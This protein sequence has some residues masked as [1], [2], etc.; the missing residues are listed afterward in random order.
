[1]ESCTFETVGEPIRKPQC[2]TRQKCLYYDDCF[3]HEKQLPD[4]SILTLI[5]SRFK[6][7]MYEKED[8]ILEMQIQNVSKVLLNSLHK[9]KQTEMVDNMLT[10][11][12][13]QTG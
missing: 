7:Q 10:T 1:M 9:S 8:Y 12:P 6:R 2:M 13:W 5:A 3:P 11:M 4:N